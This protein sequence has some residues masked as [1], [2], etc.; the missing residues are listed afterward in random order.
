M[1]LSIWEINENHAFYMIILLKRINTYN[2]AEFRFVQS[3]I[4]EA[5]S[6]AFF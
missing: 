5:S 3:V 6:K 2:C 4:L 1:S